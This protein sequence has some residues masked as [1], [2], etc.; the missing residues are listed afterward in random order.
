MSPHTEAL[1]QPG[2]CA[3]IGC[4]IFLVLRKELQLV[5]LFIFF[6]RD[7][8]LSKKDSNASIHKKLLSQIVE[9]EHTHVKVSFFRMFNQSGKESYL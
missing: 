3:T 6:Q 8:A 7:T 9:Y 4:R 2:V 1:H 5:I